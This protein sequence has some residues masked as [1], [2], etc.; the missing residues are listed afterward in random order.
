MV[1]LEPRYDLTVAVMDPSTQHR[2][3]NRALAA[4]RSL[5]TFYERSVQA[6]GGYG[7]IKS[8]HDTHLT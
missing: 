6:H 2:L 1:S 8:A 5:F 4:S 7:W 3:R